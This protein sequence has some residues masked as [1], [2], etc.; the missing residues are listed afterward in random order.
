MVRVKHDTEFLQAGEFVVQCL[1]RQYG[2]F[3]KEEL[4]PNSGQGCENIYGI[5][6][7]GK[8]RR[9]NQP[10]EARAEHGNSK[11]F[12]GKRQQFGLLT[13]LLHTTPFKRADAYGIAG[14]VPFAYGFTRMVTNTAQNRGKG[15][16]CVQESC[17]RHSTGLWLPG[18]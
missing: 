8:I 18:P 11:F 7:A 14:F 2:F 9:K 12:F 10:R 13:G 3:K 6:F 4:P 5:A 1:R 15:A 16:C 17:V